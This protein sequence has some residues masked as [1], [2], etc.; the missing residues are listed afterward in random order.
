MELIVDTP[1]FG[2]ETNRI[3]AAGLM[4]ASELENR[5]K[6]F[7]EALT[8]LVYKFF[9]NENVTVPDNYTGKKSCYLEFPELDCEDSAHKWTVW[10]DK[11]GNVEVLLKTVPDLRT[12]LTQ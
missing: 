10:P 8:S 11:I 12:L 9:Y 2:E 5:R 3:F 7:K 1:Y 6:M 4:S